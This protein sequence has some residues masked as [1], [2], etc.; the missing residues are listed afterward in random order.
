VDYLRSTVVVKNNNQD[1]LSP[2]LKVKPRSSPLNFASPIDL[3]DTNPTQ[4]AQNKKKNDD[5][6]AIM[7]GIYDKTEL[8][9]FNNNKKAL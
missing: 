1:H 5:M 4:E 8:F 6:A 9:Y 3:K 2:E 7:T